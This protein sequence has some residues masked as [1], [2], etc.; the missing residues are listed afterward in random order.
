MTDLPALLQRF[1][2]DHLIS[3]RN[4]SQHTVAA[5]R[6][7]FMLLLRFAAKITGCQPHQLTIADLNAEV[8]AGFLHHLEA[9]RGNTITT[10]NTRL[11]AIRSFYRYASYRCP[12]DA[13]HISRVLTIPIKRT[14]DCVVTYLTNTEAEALIN[15]V[16]TTTWIGQRDHALLHLAIHTGLRVSE[17]TGLTCGDVSFG[18]GAHVRCHGKGR[19]NRSTPLTKPTTIILQRWISTLGPAPTS[20][21]FPSWKGTPLSRDAVAKLLKKYVKQAIASCPSLAGKNV[22]P[23]TL[24]HTTAMLLM[25]AGTDISV[26]ALWLGHE[27]TETTQM[28]LHADMSLKEKT[29]SRLTPTS[30]AGPGRYQPSDD[31]LDF[32]ARL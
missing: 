26:I 1:F 27:S 6:D 5:Y 20:P 19:K 25:H 2:T 8:I 16:N 28:Y 24:R 3:Q 10:R 22:T 18:T 14:D 17:L 30:S 12:A 7:T 4:A 32:L 15:T 11:A 21:V 31:L 13:E 9:E 29:L 23:H